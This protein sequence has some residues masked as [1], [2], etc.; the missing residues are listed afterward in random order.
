MDLCDEYP[1][2]DWQS[3]LKNQIHAQIY[4][5]E[6]TNLAEDSDKEDIQQYQHYK[7]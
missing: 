1:A 6:G 2:N 4:A 7:P 3:S 5:E